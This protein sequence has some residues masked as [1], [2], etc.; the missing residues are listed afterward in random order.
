[1]H[2][3]PR[4]RARRDDG[5]RDR[6]VRRPV[7]ITINLISTQNPSTIAANIALNFGDSSG[8]KVNVLIVSGLVLFVVSF[9]VN[10]IGRWITSRGQARRDP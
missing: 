2:A 10:F 1:M 3:R 4:P 5:R 6:A 9:A 8:L 7:G